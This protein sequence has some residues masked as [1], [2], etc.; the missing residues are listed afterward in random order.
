MYKRE[1]Y[2]KHNNVMFSPLLLP[3]D[4]RD[5]HEFYNVSMRI[6]HYSFQMEIGKCLKKISIMLIKKNQNILPY[7]VKEHVNDCHSISLLK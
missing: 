5:G 6:L 1:G 7:F 3:W 2:L 4:A